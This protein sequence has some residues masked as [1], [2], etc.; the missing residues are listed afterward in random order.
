MET[1]RNVRHR[2]DVTRGGGNGVFW[3]VFL[4]FCLN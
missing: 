4:L 2:D 3:N 1:G